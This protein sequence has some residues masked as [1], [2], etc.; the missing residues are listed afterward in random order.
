MVDESIVEEVGETCSQMR[1]VPVFTCSHSRHNRA[2]VSAR[3][4]L[5]TKA[6]LVPHPEN[7]T[8]ASLV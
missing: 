1:A 4:G 8:V 3:E 5:L 6:L 2:R 7:R